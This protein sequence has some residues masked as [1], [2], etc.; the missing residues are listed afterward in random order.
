LKRA[1][2]TFVR[3]LLF[4][5]LCCNGLGQG[6]FLFESFL[7]RMSKSNGMRLALL[8]RAVEPEQSYEGIGDTILLCCGWGN[9]LLQIAGG[10]KLTGFKS[11]MVRNR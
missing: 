7:W 4:G 1:N 11:M 3:C 10:M 6:V 5:L 2:R 9:L 8:N